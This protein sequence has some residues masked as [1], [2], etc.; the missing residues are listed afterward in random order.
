MVLR[1]N[2]LVTNKNSVE[3]ISFVFDPGFHAYT[4]S[5]NHSTPFWD[6]AS[7][8][9]FLNC[10]PSK[11]VNKL[12]LGSKEQVASATIMFMCLLALSFISF[13]YSYATN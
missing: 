13:L 3:G 9:S 6:G 7:S 4:V 11:R 8:N 12:E 10:E 5:T 2:L 1:Y